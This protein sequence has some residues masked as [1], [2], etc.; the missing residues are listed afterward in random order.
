MVLQNMS[1][2]IDC[3]V[4]RFVLYCCTTTKTIHLQKLEW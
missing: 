3:I 2:P 1:T 4:D